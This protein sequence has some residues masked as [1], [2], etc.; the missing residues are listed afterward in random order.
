MPQV[1]DRGFLH[2]YKDVPGVERDIQLATTGIKIDGSAPTVTSPPPTL[3]EHND[4]I[5]SELG[6]S[7]DDIDKLKKDG[8]V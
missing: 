5:W 7:K 3:G 1:A 4:E 6:L 8:V 2:Q